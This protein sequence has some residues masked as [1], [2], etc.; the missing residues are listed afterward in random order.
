MKKEAIDQPRTK[1]RVAQCT[2]CKTAIVQLLN[3]EPVRRCPAC[4]C[5]E[6]ITFTAHAGITWV[7]AIEPDD[8]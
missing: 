3:T 7:G 4:S 1:T 5:N 6:M 2:R 8:R